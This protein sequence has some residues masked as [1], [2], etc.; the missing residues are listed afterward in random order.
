MQWI[1]HKRGIVLLLCLAL[2]LCAWGCGAAPEPQE[3]TLQ[4]TA[5]AWF[6]E[7]L[8][9]E[10]GM[11]LDGSHLRVGRTYNGENVFA[12]LQLPLEDAHDIA[13]EDVQQAWLCLKINGN[14]GTTALQAGL[15]TGAWDAETLTLAQAEER[16]G[17][18]QTATQALTMDGWLQID[19]TAYVRQWLAGTPNYGIA[20]FE[21]NDSTETVFVWDSAGQEDTPR[22]ELH[23]N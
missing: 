22:L 13:A 6:S 9:E 20:L 4:A 10:R 5:C 19:V 16:I 15:L 12:L 21:E 1:R 11:E 7:E 8:P 18:L 14:N 23:Y 3:L 17:P 2:L